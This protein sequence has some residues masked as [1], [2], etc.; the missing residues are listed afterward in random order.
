MDERP[1]L[2]AANTWERV[3]ERVEGATGLDP[4][5]DR[6]SRVASRAIPDRTAAKDI[7]SGTWLGHSLHPMLTDL[8]IGFWTSA[9]VLDIVGGRRSRPAAELLVGLGVLSALPTAASGASD[10][11]D[12][13]G[14]SRRVGLVH[15]LTNASAV[16]LYAWS[17]RERRRHRY[18]RGVALGMLGAS[19]ATVG[20]FLGGHLLSRRGVGVD[21]TAFLTGP[22]DWT[23]TVAESDVST[24]PLRVD[25]DGTPLL[26]LR[27]ESRILAV[28]ATCPHRGAPLDEG[29]FDDATVTCPWHGSCFAL[30][31]G[32]LLRGPSAMPL[33]RYEARVKS[34]TVEVRLRNDGQVRRNTRDL[35]HLP[36]VGGG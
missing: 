30:E 31:D 35:E 19:A 11:S 26:L 27:R 17:W 20:G 14:A 33:P 25:V 29:T 8:P 12:T 7:L 36:H 18:A 2:H 23:A 28:A 10:W 5:A 24:D 21:N 34:S 9:F 1:I 6:V 13:T 32:A 3:V 4:V 22:R 16:T 15:A